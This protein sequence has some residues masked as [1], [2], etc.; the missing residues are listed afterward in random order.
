MRWLAKAVLH[1]CLRSL[2]VAA[3]A[4]CSP[5]SVC[6]CNMLM[7]MYACASSLCLSGLKL[8]TAPHVASAVR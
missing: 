3:V 1:L 2:L 8:L 4:P 5:N 6:K 7:T